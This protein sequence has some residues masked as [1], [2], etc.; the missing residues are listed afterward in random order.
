LSLHAVTT[1]VPSRLNIALAD[2]RQLLR[3]KLAIGRLRL[4][5]KLLFL[6]RFASGCFRCSR[7]WERCATGARWSAPIPSKPLL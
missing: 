3:D 5:G 7:G 4:P 6:F 1:R 2:S